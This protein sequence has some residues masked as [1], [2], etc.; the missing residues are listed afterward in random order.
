MRIEV[1]PFDISIYLLGVAQL[2]IAYLF[3]HWIDLFESKVNSLHPGSTLVRGHTSVISVAK[4]SRPLPASTPTE[5]ST[6]ERNLINAVCAAK[7]SQL[8][9]TSITTK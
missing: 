9:A 8:Q 4:V 5:E 6:L 2:H 7:G 1:D 3:V